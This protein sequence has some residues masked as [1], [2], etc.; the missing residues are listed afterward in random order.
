MSSD[1]IY[2]VSDSGELQRVEHQ[3]YQTEDVLQQLVAKHPEL[4]AGDQ[5]DPEAPPR[6]LLLGRE[7]AIPDSVE[8]PA[9]WSLDHL[10]LDQSG[11]PTLVEVK[12]S[13]DPRI[14]REVIG[15]ML[16]YVANAQAYW[17]AGR[18]RQM[19]ADGCGSLEK[20]DQRLAEHL[21]LPGD[22]ESFAHEIER[23]WNRVEANLREGNV[24][25]LFVADQ[26]PPDLK[27]L[28][29]FLNEQFTKVE[30]LGLELRQYVGLG[31]K[32]LVPRIVGQTQAALEQKER[33]SPQGSTTGG[34]A[35]DEEK[36][37]ALVPEAVVEVF[38]HVLLESARLGLL[39]KWTAKGFNVRSQDSKAFL[40]CYEPS[41]TKVSACMEVYFRDIRDE[42]LAQNLRNRLEPV[43]SLAHGGN[44]TLRIPVTEQTA[45]D[46]RSVVDI[47]LRMMSPSR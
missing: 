45:E 17:G 30:V 27:R 26:L 25:L 11:V 46:A 2:L 7:A 32:A 41:Y 21:A 29:E 3:L 37:L 16:D 34:K 15:Q 40:Y 5:I 43:K 33:F 39:I 38:R 44:H 24:R 14:R 31:I 9:R 4:I 42:R 28:I 20:A 10:L 23:F 13:T 22:P 18:M 1:A 12:R 8:G 47:T 6:W 35:I 36:L 19:M